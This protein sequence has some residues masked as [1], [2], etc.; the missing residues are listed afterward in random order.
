M[1]FVYVY[2]LTI[3]LLLRTLHSVYYTTVGDSYVRSFQTTVLSGHVSHYGP[4][5]KHLKLELFII[6]HLLISFP[7]LKN[8]YCEYHPP[9]VLVLTRDL[10]FSSIHTDSYS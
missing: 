3:N 1:Y 8:F 10:F 2:K 5:L 7:F 4:F 9:F 6:L